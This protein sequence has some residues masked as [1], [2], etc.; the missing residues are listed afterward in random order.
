MKAKVTSSTGTQPTLGRPVLSNL[1]ALLLIT[2]ASANALAQAEPNCPERSVVVNVLDD[3]GVPVRNLWSENFRA[4]HR[5]KSLP[6]LRSEY[7]QD[8]TGRVVVLLDVSRSMS[9]RKGNNKWKVAHDVALQFVSSAPAQEQVSFIAFAAEVTQRFPAS[10][11]RAPMVAWLKSEQLTT[12]QTTKGQTAL[13]D[14]IAEAL[15]SFGTAQAGDAIYLI[16]DGGDTA[17]KERTSQLEHLLEHSGVRL[18]AFLLNDSSPNDLGSSREIS[19]LTRRSG[20]FLIGTRAQSVGAGWLSLDA[21]YYYGKD[22]AKAIEESTRVLEAQ[23]ISFYV[24]TIQ[25]PP[26]SGKP[27]LWNLGVLDAQGRRQKSMTAVYPQDLTSGECSP[28]SP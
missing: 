9:G 26:T 7:R 23:I 28:Q 15:K 19:E 13:Y 27:D 10:G 12:G 6:V 21:T 24:L 22:T 25:A 4:S 17:S 3:R 18:F 11:G 14:E 5:G 20:G 1:V 16:S 8:P 2:Y